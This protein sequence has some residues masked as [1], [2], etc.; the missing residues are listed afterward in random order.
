MSTTANRSRVG[1][2]MNLSISV[3]LAA[4][5]S[6]AALPSATAQAVTSAR[7]ASTAVSQ[8]TAEEQ[9]LTL[10]VPQEILKSS[11]LKKRLDSFNK[12]LSHI[13]TYEQA[14]QLMADTGRTVWRQAVAQAQGESPQDAAL[15]ADDD[16]ALYWTRLQMTLGVRQW[17]APFAIS[18]R[19]RGALVARLERASRGADSVAFP[20]G[21]SVKHI[22]ITGFDPFQLDD[23]IRRSNPSGAA[24]LA[25]DGT[26]IRTSS[27]EARIEAV[28]F[29]VRWQDFSEGTVERTLLPYFRPGSEQVD[30]FATI[31]QGDIGH[32]DVVRYNGNWRGGF[33]DNDNLARTGSIPV[34]AGLPTVSP[35]PQWTTTS[36]PYGEITA[37]GTGPFP[38]RDFTAVTE[39]PAGAT[40][41][42]DQPDGPTPGSTPRAGGAGDY[43]SNEI[44]YRATLLRDAL[45]A[46]LPGGHIHTP[47]LEFGS[48]NSDPNTGQISDP[49]FLRNRAA[50]TAQVRAIIKAAAKELH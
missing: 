2:A 43:L 35:Q 37:H 26:T 48:G 13:S 3:S 30:M 41:Q 6:L 49:A 46:S 18:S 10:Q 12:A 47:V 27:G 9:R 42:V 19:Q 1:S 4:C 15:G 33:P 22:L 14:Q 45:H 11:K 16:R 20:S 44:A 32:F 7:V 21:D 17:K 29:P 5:L 40:D 24:A 25:L 34:P 23:D 8:P 36:L 28:I 39:I 50:I 31:S 38:V